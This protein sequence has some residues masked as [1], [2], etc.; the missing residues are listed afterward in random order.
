M[1]DVFQNALCSQDTNQL[2]QVMSNNRPVVI[3]AEHPKTSRTKAST[4]TDDVNTESYHTS[5]IFPFTSVF[6]SNIELNY[7]EVIKMMNKPT[8][9]RCINT[10]N[11]S[12]ADETCNSSACK[13]EKQKLCKNFILFDL[14]NL[15]R[16]R[17]E[18]ENDIRKLLSNIR[19]RRARLVHE[20]S[21]T[22]PYIPTSIDPPA[23][24]S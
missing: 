1:I 16:G 11:G 21:Q 22:I 6:L 2:L 9:V 19:D 10:P 18:L 17:G 13:L 23:A 14:V 3:D 20:N 5:G 24:I 8:N 7:V 15:D 4:V 12:V